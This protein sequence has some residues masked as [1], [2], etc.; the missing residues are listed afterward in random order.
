MPPKALPLT[1]RFWSY[2][3]KTG[4]CWVWQGHLNYGYGSFTGS[5]NRSAVGQQA[6]ATRERTGMVQRRKPADRQEVRKHDHA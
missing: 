5:G 2:V 3:D 4:D 6:C 1:V